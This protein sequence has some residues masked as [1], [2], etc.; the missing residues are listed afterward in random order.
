MIQ[1]RGSLILVPTV[2]SDCRLG[3]Q[4]EGASSLSSE[5]RESAELSL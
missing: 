4:M 1:S 5:I 2:T 3:A